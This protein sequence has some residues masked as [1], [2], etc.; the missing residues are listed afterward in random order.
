M[1]WR[2]A[3]APRAGPR[4]RALRVPDRRLGAD[5]PALLLAGHDR[6][7]R[8]DRRR[9][10]RRALALDAGRGAGGH[11]VLAG[12]DAGEEPPPGVARRG[13]GR[14]RR[15]GRFAVLVGPD[16][17]LQ[18]FIFLV[19]PDF[20]S[21][22]RSR[23]GEVSGAVAVPQRLARLR[24]FDADRLRADG[25]RRHRRLARVLLPLALPVS[26]AAPR[27]C[28]RCSCCTPSRC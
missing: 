26:R 5:H 9:G 8:P 14:A 23:V 27:C 20:A 7:L 11:R 25:G 10:Y 4:R 13:R 17:H 28:A 24:Q 12:G 19:E 3:P 15:R 21:V 6:L 18:N 22:V 1:R 2:R 16:L